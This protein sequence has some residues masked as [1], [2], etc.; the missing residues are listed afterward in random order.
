MPAGSRASMIA[1]RAAR[2]VKELRVSAIDSRWAWT[3]TS[4]LRLEIGLGAIG[5]GIVDRGED[6]DDAERQQAEAQDQQHLEPG[7]E[8]RPARGDPA[9]S[10]ASLKGSASVIARERLSEL[11]Q[12]IEHFRRNVLVE[13]AVIDAAQRAADLAGGR[14]ACRRVFRR[15]CARSCRR[16]VPRPALAFLLRWQGQIVHP[17]RRTPPMFQACRRSPGT[18][19]PAE[20]THRIG[21]SE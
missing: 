12:Q 10:V 9:R 17:S 19:R 2:I 1:S 11:P 3:A 7:R 16:L 5:A 6:R 4:A 15:R 20:Q 18:G 8:P 21:G 14:A 13:R